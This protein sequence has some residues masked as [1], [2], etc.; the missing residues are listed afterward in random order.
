MMTTTWSFPAGA[1]IFTISV[2]LQKPLCGI[3]V[4]T[5]LPER[6]YS[7][8]IETP[9]IV[10]LKRGETGFYATDIPPAKTREEAEALVD[11][12]NRELGVSKGQLAAMQAGSMFGFACPAADPKNYDANGIPMKNRREKDA[13]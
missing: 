4:R 1:A 5:S 10:I 8:L 9:T 11:H 2:S 3:A 12:Y 6:C 7:T 13:R